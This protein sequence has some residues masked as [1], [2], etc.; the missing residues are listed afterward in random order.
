MRHKATTVTVPEATKEN[1]QEIMDLLASIIG[2]PAAL[3][4]RYDD[5]E[6]EVFVSS[7]SEGNPY[8]VGSREMVHGSG[9]YCE[10]VIQTRDTLLVPDARA[11]RLW[12]GN[13]DVKLNMISY[14]GCPILLPDGSPFGTLCVLDRHP[15][16]YSEPM[17]KL[18][19]NFRSLL[20]SH[21]A[22]IFLNQSLGD[23]NRQLTDYL[24]ELQ[25]LRGIIPICANCKSIRGAE[26]EWR[27]IEHYLIQHPEA[28]FS[29][30]ICPECKKA[31]YPDLE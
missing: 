12:E 30:G 21:L 5:P 11:D 31:L 17:I 23:Q 4:M 1:W 10:T 8:R 13:P 26:G 19:R 29:H 22:L 28:H 2:V 3:I 27:P 18:M 14:L 24:H 20:E 16:G 9:L 6:I 7:R 25:A 15:N